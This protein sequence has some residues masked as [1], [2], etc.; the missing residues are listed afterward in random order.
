M[1]PQTINTS[2]ITFLNRVLMARTKRC[3]VANETVSAKSM[4]AAP[5]LFDSHVKIVRVLAERVK[6]L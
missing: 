5:S 3:N 1:S 4:N 6:P 2:E